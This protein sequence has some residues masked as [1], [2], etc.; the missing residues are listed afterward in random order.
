M[1]QRLVPCSLIAIDWNLIMATAEDAF[2]VEKLTGDNYHSWKFNMKMYR[3]GKDLWE[4]VTAT[5]ML[6]ADASAEEE[7]KYRR[8]ENMAL[9]TVCL[10]ISTNLKIYVRSCKTA[11]DAWDSLAKHFEQKTLSRKIFYRRKLY[12]AR[13]QKGTGMVEHINYIKTLSEHLEAVEDPIEEKDLVIIL[14]SSLPEDYNYLITALET[15][16]EEKLT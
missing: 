11:K 7:R 13:V 16:A 8:R 14:I 1:L 15:I 9:T 12:S 3:I 5:E 4:I 2:K 6:N 10:S